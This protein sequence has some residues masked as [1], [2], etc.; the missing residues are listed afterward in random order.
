MYLM[1]CNS[2]HKNVNVPYYYKYM[3]YSSNEWWLWEP[4]TFFRLPF[5]ILLVCSGNLNS[6]SCVLTANNPGPIPSPESC[7][8][9]LKAYHSLSKMLRIWRVSDLRMDLFHFLDFRVFE[10]TLP[11]WRPPNPK[12]QNQKPTFLNPKLRTLPTRL[13]TFGIQRRLD[14]RFWTFGLEMLNLFENNRWV[15]NPILFSGTEH[16]RLYRTDAYG[17]EPT[18]AGHLTKCLSKQLQ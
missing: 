7:S 6:G 5:P 8:F 10:L 9:P 17:V 13:K 4:V 14:F 2:V 15:P 1:H 11:H 16:R 18:Y 12:M 3:M